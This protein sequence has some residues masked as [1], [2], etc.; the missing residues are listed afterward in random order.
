MKESVE[1]LQRMSN[2]SFSIIINM[3]NLDIFR[4]YGVFYLILQMRLKDEQQYDK[5]Q[6]QRKLNHLI[7]QLQKHE[8]CRYRKLFE[9]I[10]YFLSFS[11]F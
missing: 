7:S 11:S 6:N 2:N 4:I 8:L 10:K 9:I 1:L 3:S 5:C